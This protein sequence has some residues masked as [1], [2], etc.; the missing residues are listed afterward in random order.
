[1]LS[2]FLRH[3][4]RELSWARSLFITVLIVILAVVATT[5]SV[6]AETLSTLEL[7]TLEM[8][9]GI[10]VILMVIT[11]IVV[12]SISGPMTARVRTIITIIIPIIG[13]ISLVVSRAV[14]SRM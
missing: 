8:M 5:F 13:S 3:P 14:V 7:V 9:F 12:K 11:L 4:Q 2:N 10:A 1:M 6:I